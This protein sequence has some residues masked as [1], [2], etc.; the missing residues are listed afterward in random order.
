MRLLSILVLSLLTSCVSPTQTILSTGKDSGV[1]EMV[2]LY[3]DWGS[4]SNGSDPLATPAKIPHE[5][6]PEQK[7]YYIQTK[8][9]IEGLPV[10]IRHDDEI[11]K[12]TWWARQ[13]DEVM[14]DL[15]HAEEAFSDVA[16]KFQ[17]IEIK[18]KESNPD[19]R[20]N[21]QEARSNPGVMTINYML[22]KITGG[23]DGLS[24]MPWDY[25]NIGISMAY[26]ASEYIL[27]HEIG[28]YFGLLHT[29]H[30]DEYYGDYVDDTTWQDFPFCTGEPEQVPNCHNLMNYCE[31]NPTTMTRG[32]TERVRRFLRAKRANHIT[33][34]RQGLYEN[35]KIPPLPA[36][37]K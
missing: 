33:R 28:H 11:I 30:R 5:R 34:E 22:P 24:T 6:M 16:I 32:Q 7:T 36:I 18:Y 35:G 13:P 19:I 21:F 26:L 31:H 20:L 9:V 29:F 25:D 8:I 23:F 3:Q 15:A 2:A 10:K 4:T 14:R 12:K 37:L 17:I 1:T 27:A